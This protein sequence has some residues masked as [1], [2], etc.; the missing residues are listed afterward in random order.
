MND[1]DF[2]VH[3][4]RQDNEVYASFTTSSA[5]SISEDFAVRLIELFLLNYK[6][7][8]DHFNEIK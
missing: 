8:E 5:H 7:W 3:L 6:N 4:Y 1:F 2:S